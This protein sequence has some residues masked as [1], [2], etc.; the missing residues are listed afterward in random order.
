MT[1]TKAV[2]CCLDC[3]AES[4]RWEGRCPSCG[5]WNTLIEA[6][7][8]SKAAGFRSSPL[9]E[10]A[11]GPSPLGRPGESP[12]V[13]L[14]TEFGDVDRVL[15]GGLVP[16]S[17]LLLGGPPGVGKSTLLLQLAARFGAEG[18]RVLYASGEESREQ[19]RLRAQRLGPGLE[20]VRFF[21]STDVEEILRAAESVAPVVL[22]VDSIQA[23]CSARLP[24]APG[25]VAQVRE[26][27]ALLQEWSKRSGVAT[28]L[29]GHVTKGGVLAGPRTLEHLVDV[30]LYFEG[31]RSSEHRLLRSSKNRFGSVDEV[32]AFRMTASGLEPVLD[33]SALFVSDRPD[34]VSGSAIAVPLQGT[35]PLLAEVQALTARA[36]FASP[37]R[38]C[39][40]FPAR[41]LAI[42]LAVL[43][44]R[45]GQRLAE[46]DVFVSVVGGLRLA[47]PAA[48]LPLVAALLSADRDH[49][50][51]PE[52]AFV[53][54]IGLGGEVRGVTHPDARVRVARGAGMRHLVLPKVQKESLGA[55]GNGVIFV[56]H[57]RDVA[58]LLRD[59]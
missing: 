16:G 24:S 6:P 7:P 1:K 49:P 19:V 29:V 34:G 15:G 23:T 47:D 44:R 39:T 55:G 31:P 37:Q 40:G 56:E 45:A 10:G 26:C 41:R 54:E 53:G 25:G 13:R 2:Y 21:A 32:A 36:R 46:S 5:E 22:C 20:E 48:D 3:G 35:R 17:L 28:V 11:L 30:V 38:V 58:S 51:P 57:V 59:S 42:L 27:A 12:V 50:L 14:C 4:L 9:P 18:K 8:A 33:P 43:E 52:T